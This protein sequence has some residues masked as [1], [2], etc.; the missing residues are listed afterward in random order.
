M[1]SPRASNIDSKIGSTKRGGEIPNSI[2][3]KDDYQNGHLYLNKKNVHIVENP[4]K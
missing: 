1:F 2:F 3:K 4:S